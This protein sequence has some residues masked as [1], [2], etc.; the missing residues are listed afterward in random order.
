MVSLT[1]LIYRHIN[2]SDI[3]FWRQANAGKASTY[4]NVCVKLWHYRNFT[5][6]Y[7]RSREKNEGK[8]KPKKS[9][10][11]ASG[12]EAKR[13]LKV[14]PIKSGTGGEDEITG[15]ELTCRPKRRIIKGRRFSFWKKWKVNGVLKNVKIF[16][17]FKEKQTYEK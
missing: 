9:Q 15:D 17:F 10:A 13:Q 6:K 1:V 7:D 12:I 4:K 14:R 11:K 2:D 5:Q 3:S 8:L 16:E